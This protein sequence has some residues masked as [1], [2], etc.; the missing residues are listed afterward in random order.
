MIRR[1][2]E[3]LPFRLRFF[4]RGAFFLLA[5][6][7]AAL[8]V[9]E[10]REEK[11]LSYLSYRDVFDKNVGE[12]TARLQH[13]TGQ[14]ALLNPTL[15]GAAQTPL[16]PLLL[17]FSAIDF[18]DKAKAQ[19]AA[20]MAGC[21][22]QYPGHAQLCVSIGNNP[23][24]GG[25]IYA[26]GTFMSG[27]LVAH[28]MGDTD[29]A[30]A[31]RLGVE[32]AMR[33]RTY[34]WIAPLEPEGEQGRSGFRGRLTGFALDADGRPGGRPDK[35]FRGWLWQ[36]SRCLDAA[37][38][39]G[40]DCPRRSFFSVRLPIAVFK[41]EL[42]D[43]PRMVWPPADLDA[44][45]VRVRAF[46]PGDAAPIF[47]SN[48]PGASPPFALS[49]LRAQLLIGETLQIR[50]L[51]GHGP[52]E[53]ISL[54]HEDETQARPARLLS[55]IIRRLSVGG[56]DAPLLARRV[57]STPV[58]DFEI[59]L[60]GDFRSVDRSLGLVAS[61]LSWS[62]AAMLAAI[63]LTW[64]AIEIGIIRRITLLTKRAASVKRS[65]GGAEALEFDLQGLRGRDE[66][67][68]LAG[69]L[70]D[71]MQRINEDAQRER[72]RADQEKNMWHAIGHEIMGPLQSLAALHALPQDS[73]LRYVERMR[74][75]VRVLY[76]SASPSDAILSAALKLST[77]DIEAF[78]RNV[79][80]NAIHAGIEHVQFEGEGR[81]TVV[82][83]DEYSLEDV[84][85]HVLSN[86]A[87]FRPPGTAIRMSLRSNGT[88]A[89]VRI[90]N[91][92]RH[93]DAALLGKIFEYGVSDPRCDPNAGHRGQG[94][95]VAKTYMAK[96]GGTIAAEN[97]ADGVEFVLTLATA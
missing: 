26:V 22:V 44:I 10:L 63:T 48:R 1:W 84:V 35:E 88:S 45:R 77:V 54:T 15:A 67:G 74:Q 97:L 38:A 91:E 76:G 78:L 93:I 5:L 51:T 17:P 59:S 32:V 37:P 36:D 12:I 53:I 33:G 60:T 21:L 96:M 3:R 79:A 81:P 46:A 6:A 27:P 4:F 47:D 57:V 66:L 16:H 30:R 8:A 19:Q 61:R 62:V 69:V 68:L 18:D 56:Y 58:G 80:D 71:L 83:A 87:R 75:A 89:V 50:K 92:G 9:S 34:Q 11:K 40:A 23:I 52:V 82:K 39:S 85:T 13:P 25:F 55:E 14:L 70:A 24:A 31:H 7:S 64:I 49:D 73:S 72:I 41:E 20:E 95:Y 43:G 42:G 29:L 28:D 90:R 94:L 65:V 86:A 2:R